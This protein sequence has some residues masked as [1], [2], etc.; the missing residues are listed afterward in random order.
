MKR[1]ELRQDTIANSKPPQHASGSRS[2]WTM[3]REDDRKRLRR[4]AGEIL[5]ARRPSHSLGSEVT[6]LI[7]LL[8]GL[9]PFQ[10]DPNRDISDGETRSEQGLA[11][12]P[13]MAAMCAEDLGRT[14]VFIRGLHD[15]VHDQVHR[16]PG[17]PTRVLYCGCGPYALLALPLMA[18]APL[19]EV[20][21]TLLDIHEQSVDS[22]RAL[23]DKLGYSD[24]VSGYEVTDA[25]RYQIPPNEAPD[26][27]IMEIMNACLEK[28]PQVPITR[29]LLGQVPQAR[30][31]PE[32][33]RVEARLVN[34]SHEFSAVD[35]PQRRRDRISLGTVFE[36]SA[37][38]VE[39]WSHLGNDRLPASSIEIPANLEDCYAPMLFTIVQVHGDWSLSDY[40]SGLTV[41][42]PLPF[43]G[44]VAA[45]GRIDF[46][47]RLGHN[48]A[49]VG[50]RVL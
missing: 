4:L 10:I 18:T 36:L 46:H 11:L 47:Y 19:G 28:E 39:A 1:P 31:V 44:P 48:P 43:I 22:A 37:E 34:L 25:G 6:E 42:R 21:F 20:R 16:S 35:Q 49:L 30:L 50:E 38:T 26:V 24:C 45:G 32:S 12:S 40:D 15:A 13:T 27:I 5:D 17:P 3:T 7:R 41:P 29:H 8:R 23:I 33:V 2:Q 9:A 14:V